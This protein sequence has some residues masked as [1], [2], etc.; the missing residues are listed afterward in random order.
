MAARPKRRFMGP[1]LLIVWITMT[2]RCE[3]GYYR[4]ELA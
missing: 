3:G 1:P 2:L 4:S